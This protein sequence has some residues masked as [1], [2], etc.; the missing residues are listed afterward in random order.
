M[1][2]QVNNEPRVSSLQDSEIVK[3]KLYKEVHRDTLSS[4]SSMQAEDET[5][6]GEKVKAFFTF[7]WTWLAANVFCWCIKMRTEE[8]VQKEETQQRFEGLTARQKKE[9]KEGI[10]LFKKCRKEAF[11]GDMHSR[12]KE[13]LQLCSDLKVMVKEKADRKQI[14]EKIDE[15]PIPEKV[16][17]ELTEYTKKSAASQLKDLDERE[18][19]VRF[20]IQN[21]ELFPFAMVMQQKLTKLQSEAVFRSL[22]PAG[23]EGV[24]KVYRRTNENPSISAED[25]IN[26]ITV[27]P[28]IKFIQ[29]MVN[30][31][32]D[33]A[34]EEIE[35][36]GD[37]S[38]DDTGK[39]S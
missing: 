7:I 14:M 2:M 6:F 5:S 30:Q 9:W 11:N 33:D 26:I 20:L 12:L 36:I 35:A 19:Y 3:V 29:K 37:A 32:F 13:E 27:K 38:S 18:Q 21:Y 22:S 10:D 39:K 8:V 4:M 25:F 31:I 28:D 34:K 24:L 23:R 15:A 16:K 1:G 17:K